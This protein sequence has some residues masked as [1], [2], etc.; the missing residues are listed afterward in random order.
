MWAGDTWPRRGARTDPGMYA[1][2]CLTSFRIRAATAANPRQLDSRPPI[3]IVLRVATYTGPV[4]R[5]AIDI[6]FI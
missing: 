6:A 5:K 3:R 2:I 1:L 4:N